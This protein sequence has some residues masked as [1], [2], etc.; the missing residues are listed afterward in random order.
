[1]KKRK[2]FTCASLKEFMETLN[3]E[4]VSGWRITSIFVDTK[5]RFSY[6]FSV[7]KI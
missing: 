4:H 1:M 5:G 7:R 3:K 2:D 6:S